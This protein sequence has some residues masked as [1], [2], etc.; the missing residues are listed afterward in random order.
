MSHKMLN[1]VSCLVYLLL[2]P[3]FVTFNSIPY[4][5]GAEM[6]LD[7][8]NWRIWKTRQNYTIMYLQFLM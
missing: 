5:T 8:E 3:F 4:A 7:L 6:S 2:L 1:K